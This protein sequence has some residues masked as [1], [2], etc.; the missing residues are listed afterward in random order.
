MIVA[1]YVGNH[2]GD[3]LGMI[4][5]WLIRLGQ[6]RQVFGKVTHCEAVL[7]GHWYSAVICGASRRDGKRVRAKVTELNPAH[8]R[9]LEIPL[10]SQPEWE[11]Q[12]RPLLGT[13]YSD[14]GAISSASP[15]LSLLLGPFVGP[16]ARLG[17]WCSRFILQGAGVVG[18]EDMSVSEAMTY[19]VNL[20]GTVDITAEFFSTPR[21]GNLVNIEPPEHPFL[22]IQQQEAINA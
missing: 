5:Y 22:K 7:A 12:A 6:W 11:R 8:W 17:Q 15:M 2:K 3:L 4:G 13:P 14:A 9:I 20:P 10:W 19:A 21:P 16:I 18:A 1:W